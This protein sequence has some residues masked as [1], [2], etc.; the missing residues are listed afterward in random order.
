MFSKQHSVHKA[1]FNHLNL[2]HTQVLH[3]DRT[4]PTSSK[5]H[6][7][8]LALSSCLVLFFMLSKKQQ[9]TSLTPLIIGKIDSFL[10][11]S[12]HC[13]GSV[14]N[15]QLTYSCLYQPVRRQR[16]PRKAPETKP[17]VRPP[18]GHSRCKLPLRPLSLFTPATPVWCTDP[19]WPQTHG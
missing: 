3:N 17:S 1:W 2:Q 10:Y 12:Y 8:P 15:A 11:K 14:S 7:L 16:C 5:R 4:C 6:A 13:S 9:P 18:V 19:L